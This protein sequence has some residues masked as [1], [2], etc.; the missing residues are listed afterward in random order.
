MGTR[1]PN[2]N[3][4]ALFE[5]T[6]WTERQLAQA[7]NRLGTERG[8][9]TRY[10]QPS[11]SQWLGGGIPKKSARGLIVEA[12]ARKLGRPLT[13]EQLGFPA[14]PEKSDSYSLT[15]SL[16]DLGSRDMERRYF[17]GSA[18]F[19][20]ALKIPEWREIS[21]RAEAVQSGQAQEMGMRDV[22]LVTKITDHLWMTFEQFGGHHTR[23]MAAQFLV[24]TVV[25]YLRTHALEA[26]RKAM[27]SAASFLCYLTGW[28]AEDEGRHG[29]AQRYYT[30][31]LELARESG[32]RL[33]Y[34]RTIRGLSVQAAD[35]GH[36]PDAKRF[37]DAAATA[38]PDAGP[39][40]RAFF[41]AQQGYASAVAGE[42]RA[43]LASIRE[44]EKFLDISDSGPGTLGG[45]N[46]SILA[47]ATSN[48]RYHSGD[49]KGSMDS[50]HLHFRL[51]GTGDTPRS[52]ARFGSLLAERQLELGHLEE[53]CG[54][55]SKV[56]DAYPNIYSGR[57]DQHVANIE[58]LLRPYLA[59]STARDTFERSRLA[60]RARQ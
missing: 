59:N 60:S 2:E 29:L 58:S 44:A 15:E 39:R 3:L 52:A 9:P 6:G 53:A 28:M 13:H 35:L 43:A 57:V 25:P 19:S 7:V 56:L 36:G 16:I 23:P 47:Y 5:E 40:N 54:T 17:I 55:W 1:E 50:L 42:S 12:F 14:P 31:S 38:A 11:V 48:V 33:A 32:D 34:C 49:I 24:H 26:P 30:K 41:A 51:R 37:A 20:V 10:Q 45:F 46:P 8:T 22:E 4:A 18:L 21:E 27:L